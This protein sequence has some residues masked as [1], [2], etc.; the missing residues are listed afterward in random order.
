MQFDIKL[1]FVWITKYRKPLLS[2]TI[3]VR[4]RDIVRQICTELEVDIL[5]GHVSKDHV[6]L[7]VSCPPHLSPSHLM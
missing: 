3:A 7:Y 2:G 4:V 5:K 6:R 1:H